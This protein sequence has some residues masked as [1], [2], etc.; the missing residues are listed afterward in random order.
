M[1]P[2][3]AAA[4]PPLYTATRVADL[5][6]VRRLLADGTD[7]EQRE[8]RHR[9]TALFAAVEQDAAE[10]VAALLDAGAEPAAIPE[11]RWRCI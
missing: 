3:T 8:R 7:V 4:D 5:D 10:I 1:V 11:E 2:T 6:G 9:R